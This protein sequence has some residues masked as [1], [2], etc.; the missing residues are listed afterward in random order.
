M[1]SCRKLSK[2]FL[3]FKKRLGLDISVVTCNEQDII[4][5][6]H[7]KFKGEIILIQYCIKNKR[8][9]AFFSKY[10]LAIEVDEYNHEDRNSNYEKNRQ[11]MIE[12]HGITMIR[13]NP[14]ASNFDMNRLI[15]RIYMHIS[16]PNKK[17]IKK[18][19]NKIK[20]LEDKI[21][22]LRLQLTNLSVQNNDDNV[23]DNDK[24]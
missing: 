20:E 5:A 9:D 11:L 8:I 14:D 16:Q 19:Q 18:K 10:K 6:L 13:T 7:T 12:G 15:N 22:K 24:K 21:K 2:K 3:K 23:N 4:S 1:K 17:K